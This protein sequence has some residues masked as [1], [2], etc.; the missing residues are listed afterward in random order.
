MGIFDTIYRKINPR[1]HI[2]HVENRNNLNEEDISKLNRQR[3]SEVP[4][5][6]KDSDIYKARIPEFL[7]NPAFGK[8][9]NKDVFELRRVAEFPYALMVINTVCDEISSIDWGIRAVKDEEVPEELIKKTKDWIDNPNKNEESFEHILRTGTR[10]ILELDAGV[11]VK[12]YNRQGDFVQLYSRDAGTFTKNPNIYG[13]MPEERAYYQYGWNVP[14]YP[15]PFNKNEIVYMMR[16]PRTYSVYGYSPVESLQKTLQ[17]LMYGLDSN[18]E[19]FTSNEV[20]KGVFTM[21]GAS[22]DNAKAL[23]E[24]LRERMTTKDSAG[25]WKKDVYAMPVIPK[26]GKFERIAFS[27]LELQLLEQQKWFMKIVFSSFGVTPSEMGFTEDSNKS[28]D[29]VQDKIQKRKITKP[30]CKMWSYYINSQIINDL[31]WIKGTQYEGKIEFFFDKGDLDEEIKKRTLIWGDSDRNLITTNEARVEMGLEEIKEPI[32]EPE[33]NE[34]NPCKEEEDGDDFENLKKKSLKALPLK[35]EIDFNDVIWKP[36]T[37]AIES[38]L[39]IQEKIILSELKKKMKNPIAKIKSVEKKGIL[40][41]LLGLFSLESLKPVVMEEIKKNY[42]TGMDIVEK[43]FDR[44]FN[45]PKEMEFIEEYTFDLVKNLGDDTREKLRTTLQRGILEH[46][47]YTELAKDI[48]KVFKVSKS[49]SESIAIS[50]TNRAVNSGGYNAIVESGQTGWIEPSTIN[51][52]RRSEICTYLSN[53]RVRLGEKFHYKGESW[54][55][56][57]FHP[58][59]R[60]GFSFIP[61]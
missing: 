46:S 9:F 48:R 59:C 22:S 32:N 20:P 34:N 7:I 8:P 23:R 41:F 51:D 15:I 38:A 33:S 26:A 60:S 42:F 24:Q 57:P 16:N 35:I 43:K 6:K 30:F 25:N 52:H 3:E 39:S 53:K 54:L 19:Y 14:T 40:D 28:T 49:R 36:L 12:V 55:H 31:P 11:L 58:R 27:N 2:S 18:L 37:K 1:E 5:D 61:D 13:V 45:Y 50:E 4:F 29:Q 17:L 10:D 56:P 44:N 21:D 47:S